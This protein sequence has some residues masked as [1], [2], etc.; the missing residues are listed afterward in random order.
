M[1]IF[2]SP[3]IGLNDLDVADYDSN[4]TAKVKTNLLSQFLAVNGKVD[5]KIK[6]DEDSSL[7]L[8]FQSTLRLKDFQIIYL[9]LV[10]AIYQ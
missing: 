1:K 9:N 4:S 10:M 5:K 3:M 8:S 2:F 6:T 7:N